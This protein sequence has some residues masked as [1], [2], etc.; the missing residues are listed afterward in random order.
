MYLRFLAIL[1]LH[2][3]H[4]SSVGQDSMAFCQNTKIFRNTIIPFTAHQ[5]A[6]RY[7]LIVLSYYRYCLRVGTVGIL[8]ILGILSCCKQEKRKLR[9]QDIRAFPHK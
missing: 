7:C 5:C 9:N 8:Q 6:C 3:A 1:K 2:E 4:K